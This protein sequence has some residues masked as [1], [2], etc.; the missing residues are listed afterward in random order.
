MVA[1]YI[2]GSVEQ[3]NSFSA[4]NCTPPCRDSSAEMTLQRASPPEFYNHT[5]AHCSAENPSP[6]RNPGLKGTL[7]DAIF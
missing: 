4:K 5:G 2:G 6:E 7:M 3:N 1:L